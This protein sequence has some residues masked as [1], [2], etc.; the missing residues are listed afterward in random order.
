MKIA[1]STEEKKM[2]K[3]MIVVLSA[4]VIAVVFF[5]VV[6]IEVFYPK[7]KPIK[8]PP[9]NL[10]SS[11]TLSGEDRTPEV[12]VDEADIESICSVIADVKPTRRQSFDDNPV[13]RPYCKIEIL[14]S[15]I[16]YRYYIYETGTEVFIEVP[17]EGIYESNKHAFDYIMGYY[18]NVGQ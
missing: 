8:V 7:A 3:I 16:W 18:Q 5:I 2:K 13:V 14:A 10:I 11:V 4:S 6:F 17:Y 15:D 9:V 1:H 12:N